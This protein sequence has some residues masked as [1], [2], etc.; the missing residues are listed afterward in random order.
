LL[1]IYV[2]LIV[3]EQQILVLDE[4]RQVVGDTSALPCD[5]EGVKR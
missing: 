5:D 2:W 4:E 3:G 1:T